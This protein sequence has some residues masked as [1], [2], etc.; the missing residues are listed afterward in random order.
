M[1]H[2]AWETIIDRNRCAKLL[3][4]LS[5]LAYEQRPALVI[6]YICKHLISTLAGNSTNDNDRLRFRPRRVSRG[7]HTL[8]WHV[9]HDFDT[10]PV[11][12]IANCR[13]LRMMGLLSLKQHRGYFPVGYRSFHRVVD[14]KQPLRS[15]Q[16]W[17]L[18]VPL[19]IDIPG[20]LNSYRLQW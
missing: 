9:E 14:T 6:V 13:V 8:K 3:L 15:R 1:K 12:K 20:S 10:V 4:P 7:T 11:P 16:H 19:I 17:P 18:S 2:H 5:N